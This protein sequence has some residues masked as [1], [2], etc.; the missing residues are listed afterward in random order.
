M[1]TEVT[2]RRNALDAVLAEFDK[3]VDDDGFIV[4]EKTGDPVLTPR[5]EE[6]AVEDLA[7]LADGS[8]IYIDDNFVSI[9]EYVER[10]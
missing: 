9:L 6:V 10:D 3:T 7:G 1:S 4:E 5:G 8:E 2:V